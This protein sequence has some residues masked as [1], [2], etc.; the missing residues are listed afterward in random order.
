M[1]AASGIS[2][3]ISAFLFGRLDTRG[4]EWTMIVVPMVLM[5]PLIALA[6]PASGAL[7]PISPEL[8]L[9][10]LLVLMFLFGFVNG[11]SDIALFTVR[12]RRTEPAWMGRA[13]AVSM[14]FNFSGFPVGAAIAGALVTVSLAAT[15]WL[16]VGACLLA[17]ILAAVL[18]PRHEPDVAAPAAG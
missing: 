9:G 16:G 12:Q 15:I 2:G 11:C 1:F 17:A 13:F 3:M 8:G 18:V 5:A 10:L 4:R 7:G 14:A 6:L